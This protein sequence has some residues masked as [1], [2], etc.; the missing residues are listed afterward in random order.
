MYP[1]PTPKEFENPEI[2]GCALT[3]QQRSTN[4]NHSTYSGFVI[5]IYLYKVVATTIKQDD[6]RRYTR[7][8]MLP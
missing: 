1:S 6:W 5:C 4:G 7:P 3:N 8:V 2:V